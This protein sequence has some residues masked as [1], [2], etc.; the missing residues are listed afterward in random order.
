MSNTLPPIFNDYGGSY[1]KVVQQSRE[2]NAVIKSKAKKKID[3]WLNK[4]YSLIIEEEK[5]R[6][7]RFMKRKRLVE[8]KK[9]HF[10]KKK[11]KLLENREELNVKKRKSTILFYKKL[12]MIGINNL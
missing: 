10:L 5:K 6:S 7:K 11:L 3:D 9:G 12:A 8:R 1:D 4:D 2:R